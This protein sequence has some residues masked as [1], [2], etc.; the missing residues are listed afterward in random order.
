MHVIHKYLLI[1]FCLVNSSAAAQCTADFYFLNSPGSLSVQFR[2]T[3]TAGPGLRLLY[4]WQFGEGNASSGQVNPTHTYSNPGTYLVYLSVFDSMNTCFDSTSRYVTVTLPPCQASFNHRITPAG[5]SSFVDFTNTSLN[6]SDS[7]IFTYNFG[8]GTSFQ[9]Q[10]VNRNLD[11]RHLYGPGTYIATLSIVDSLNN[12]TCGY[13]DTI[14]IPTNPKPCTADFAY[15]IQ[16]LQDSSRVDFINLSSHVDSNAIFTYDFGDGNRL[17]IPFSSG[18]ID[19]SWVYAPGSYLVNL[20]IADPV[21]GDSCSKSDSILI[22][23]NA[24]CQADFDYSFIGDSVI[25]TNRAVGFTSLKYFFGDGDS[26]FQENPIHFYAQSNRYTVTMIVYDSLSACSDTLSKELNVTISTSCVARFVPAIDTSKTRL[27]YLINQSSDQGSHQYLWDFGDG[28]TALGKTPIHT[29]ANY[30]AYPI[31]LTVSDSLLNCVNQFCDT[32]GLDS[33]SQVI[34]KS[35]G[36]TLEVLDGSAIG[37]EERS[38]LE[39]LRVYPNPVKEKLHVD[40]PPLI[41]EVEFQLF[42]V[43]GR[44]IHEG[45]IDHTNPVLNTNDLDAGIYLLTLKFQNRLKKLKVLKME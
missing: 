14:L 28:N 32:I 30:G 7:A 11:P 34:N 25:F 40:F 3:S 36:F 6:Y 21:S 16:P 24:Y 8:D 19:T 12:T 42:T 13:L 37:I 1:L 35:L 33:T 18:N 20:R 17:N 5:D 38:A 27:L 45:K 9:T 43:H 15:S 31:C 10:A 41:M 4:L 44:I 22:P 23:F 29:Y 2:D 26:S 39:K